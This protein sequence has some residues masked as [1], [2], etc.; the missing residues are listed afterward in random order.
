MA[1][2]ERTP[3]RTSGR[4]SIP[5]RAAAPDA[6]RWSACYAPH[7]SMYFDQFGK[8]RACC[9][10]TGVYLGDITSQSLREIWQSASADRIRSALEADDYSAGCEFCEW[11]LREGNEAIL[12]ARQYDEHPPAE[13]RPPWPRLME[14]SV[15]NTCNLACIMCNGEFSSTIRSKRE[16]R[17]PLEAVYGEQ[18]YADLAP[19]LPHLEEVRFLGGE[20]FLGREPLRIMEMIAELDRLPRVTI[21][22]NATIRTA[23]VERIVDLLQPHIVVSLDGASPATYDAIRLGARFDE[24]MANLDWFR[25]VLGPGR[26]SITHCLMTAN[27]HEFADLLSLAEERE[28]EVGVNVVRFPEALSLYHL[29]PDQLEE[30]V[31]GLQGT[32]VWHLTGR[33]RELWDG[34]LGALEHRLETI[35]TDDGTLGRHHGLPGSVVIE[36]LPGADGERPVAL[37]RW[38]WLPFPELDPADPGP[39]PSDRT[40]PAI[41]ILLGTDA[42]LHISRHDPLGEFEL[43]HLDGK[44]MVVFVDWLNATFGP[45]SGWSYAPRISGVDDNRFLVHLTSAATGTD[46][47]IRAAARRDDLGTLIGARLTIDLPA[48]DPPPRDRAVPDAAAPVDQ[49]HR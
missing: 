31:G 15:T 1:E 24:V 32:A 49:Q 40:R 11:Q 23:R 37:S 27:W 33:R 25:K 10:N 30:V 34:H 8:V 17:T 6:D 35:R 5:V 39:E 46:V 36:L 2:S 16:G 48:D 3:A 9:Q 13:R 44:T 21:T 38:P 41:E 43:R 45:E 20:P 4:R 22:T 12:F 28:M 18:F 19:F 42:V 14:F 7:T 47:R 29:E 26:V